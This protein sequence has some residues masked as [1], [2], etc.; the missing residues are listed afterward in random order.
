MGEITFEI[1][2]TPRFSHTLL[3]GSS[4]QTDYGDVPGLASALYESLMFWMS[5]ELLLFGGHRVQD[6]IKCGWRSHVALGGGV[7]P[8][9][10][11]G[12]GWQLA[13]SSECSTFSGLC[14][15]MGA[16]V[17]ADFCPG[18]SH[19]YIPNLFMRQ[20]IPLS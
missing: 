4:Q 11:L 8:G 18:N 2:L 20:N 10:G 9:P 17:L 12:V 5:R 15:L 7:W 6:G 1:L 13:E 16:S 14:W 3:W 19:S